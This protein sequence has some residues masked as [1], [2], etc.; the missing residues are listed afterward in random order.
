MRTKPQKLPLI[1]TAAALVG[2]AVLGPAWRSTEIIIVRNLSPSLPPG[3]YLVQP[4]HNVSLG[5]IAVFRL[6]RDVLRKVGGRRW[7]AHPPLLIKP[8]A[9]VTGAR[10]CHWTSSIRIN[11]VRVGSTLLTDSEGL[12]LP[13]IRGCYR[14]RR[15]WFLPLSNRIPNSFDGRYFGAL[16]PSLL[17]GRAVP[18]LTWD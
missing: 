7:L 17:L 4:S 12:E 6:P 15:G 9:A 1:A 16:P 8:T 13:R 2:L 11:G 10:V 3:F 5:E 14:I 18:L